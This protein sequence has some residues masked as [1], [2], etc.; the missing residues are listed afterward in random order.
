V[1]SGCGP[2]GLEET[3]LLGEP[4]EGVVALTLGSDESGKGVC[5]G[6]AGVSSAL[7]NLADGD[8]D[9]SVV[10]GLCAKCIRWM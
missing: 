2:D 8:L 3:I 10:L 1:L 7:V 6:L 9:G 5:D 4:V